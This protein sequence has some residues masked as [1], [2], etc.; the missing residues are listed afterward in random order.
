MIKFR[1]Y[2]PRIIPDPTIKEAL[3]KLPKRIHIDQKLL[4]RFSVL[5]S[6]NLRLSVPALKKLMKAFNIA[7]INIYSDD[8]DKQIFYSGFVRDGELL[9]FKP[10]IIRPR[11]LRAK[12]RIKDSYPLH[13]ATEIEIDVYVNID[14]FENLFRDK[15]SG[16]IDHTKLKDPQYFITV[17]NSLL[18]RG[19]KLQGLKFNTVDFIYEGFLF[20]AI[21]SFLAYVPAAYSL[22]HLKNEMLDSFISMFLLSI[23]I[24]AG[25]KLGYQQVYNKYKRDETYTFPLGINPDLIIRTILLLLEDLN[26]LYFKEG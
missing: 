21:L 17:F 7:K 6:N 16:R 2:M 24:M 8:E 23:L 4:E 10:T 25:F 11:K 20:E 14:E 26:I 19:I 12:R 22:V 1:N 15:A 18:Q 9:A 3:F 13:Y 5:E